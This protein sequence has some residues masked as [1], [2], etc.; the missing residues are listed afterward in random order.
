MPG[1]E[2]DPVA[3][4][5][6]FHV[7]HPPCPRR[8][9]R[10][11]GGCSRRSAC[12]SSRR[13]PRSLADAGVVRGLIGPR[14]VPRLWDRHLLNCA[15][16]GEAVPEGVEVCDIGSGAGLPG[17]VLAIARPDLRLT[18]VEPLVAAH[19]L[20]VR[21]RRRARAGQ[22]RGRPRTGGRPARR[23]SVR[24][25]HLAGSGAAGA[26]AGMVHAA[27][28]AHRVLLAMKGSSIA[29]E[30]DEYAPTWRR[31]GCADAGGGRARRGCRFSTDLGRSGGLG[32]PGAGRLGR[33]SG[34][35]R[36][37]RPSTK[38]RGRKA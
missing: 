3:A 11:P 34:R 10:W 27:G 23:A 9:P 13:T 24:R 4:S 17:L 30:I 16:L 19:H 35:P 33:R 36:F 28:I 31:L 32:R 37:Q 25:R 21:G 5:P 2:A 29:A 26:A 22:R 20:S 6:L 7:K 15:V 18:L 14:E 12:R 1:D 8:P 38:S